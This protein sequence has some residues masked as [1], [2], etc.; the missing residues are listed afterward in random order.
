MRDMQSNVLPEYSIYPAA[1]GA[2]AKTGDAVVDLQGFEGALILCGSG[3]ITADMAF[4]LMECD[5]SGGTY[6]AVAD[7]DL[8]GSEP[9]LLEAMRLRRSRTSA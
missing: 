6:T 2:A 1:L 5:T 3:A 9:T 7:A 4:Q 8:V